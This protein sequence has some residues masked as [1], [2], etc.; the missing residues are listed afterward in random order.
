L[1]FNSAFIN[2]FFKITGFGVY[3]SG[4]EV[5][6]TEYAFD[7]SF[8]GTYTGIFSTRPKTVPSDAK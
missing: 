7:G 2:E 3:H 5:Y 8:G 1:F 4:V 6:G